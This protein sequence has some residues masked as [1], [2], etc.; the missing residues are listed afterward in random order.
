MV[1]RRK[2]WN[3]ELILIKKVDRCIHNKVAAVKN[4][5]LRFVVIDCGT[6]QTINN[7]YFRI[8]NGTTFGSSIMYYCNERFVLVGSS[9]RNCQIKNNRVQ[10]SPEAPTC[11][12]H[13]TVLWRIL[14][15]CHSVTIF[16]YLEKKKHLAGVVLQNKLPQNNNLKP[17]I[18]I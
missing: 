7:G 5:S 8:V 17:E 4:N 13:G 12:L 1:I 16:I 9:S 15:C 6:P 3:V 11:I 14:A 2:F 18:Q 10:W